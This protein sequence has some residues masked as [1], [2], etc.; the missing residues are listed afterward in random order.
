MKDLC[1]I[2]YYFIQNKLFTDC[3]SDFIPG[4]SCVAQLLSFTHEIY[5]IFDCNPPCDIRGTFLD[6][7]KAFDKVWHKSLIFKLKSYGVDDSLLKLIGNYLTGRQQRVVLNGQTS[8]WKNILAG[9]P[10]GSVLGPLLFLVY[11]NDLPNGIES[12]CK[13][14]ADD[15]SLFSEVKDETSS[16]TQLNNDLNKISKW[17]FQW[18]MFN[19][20]PSKQTI[21]ICFSHK[22]E[23]KNYSSLMFNDTK[24]Q[25]AT[26]QKHLRLILDSILDFNEHIDYK[27]DKCNKIVGIM[28]RLSLTLS[29]KSLLTIYKSFVRPVLD[30]A[31]I[32]YDKPF[33]E[34]FK[35]KIEMVQYR[36]AFAITGAMKGTSRDRLYQELGLESLADRRWSRR[37]FFFHKITQRL[38]PSYLQTYHNAV[39]EGAYLTRSATQNKIEP[40]PARTKVFENSFFPYCIREW[41]KLSDKIRNIESINKFKVAIFNFIRPK[42]N[43]VFNIHDT[44]GIKL[45]SRLRLNFSHLNEN[46]FRHS[47]NNR[48]DPMCTCGLEPEKTLHYLLRCSL[49]STQR[50]ELFNNVFILNP[51]IKNYSNEKLLN[52][53]L[54][55]SEDFK[56]NLN[57]EILKATIKFLK[58]S[59]RFNDPL[60]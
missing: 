45:L 44:N 35:R 18:K 5:K 39:S 1:L 49:F 10:Q 24:V 30:Y 21:E 59:E 53:L 20:D 34:S 40:I 3:Q 50:L 51:S 16:D 31:D 6:I 27:I 12:T 19:P 11:I 47:F 48:V 7:S 58:R 36:A 56:W 23:N 13:I 32:N 33:N 46:I 43:S 37:L 2:P 17:A 25:L 15:T 4:D 8:S 41:S 52:V 22:R 54:Y 29:R 9:V 60:F 28:K 55:G 26:S 14:F 42:A 38:L 57:K